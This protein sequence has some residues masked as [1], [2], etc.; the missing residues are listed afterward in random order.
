M[1]IRKGSDHFDNLDEIEFKAGSKIG[2]VH[3]MG[4]YGREGEGSGCTVASIRKL[5]TRRR[6]VS[7]CIFR[8]LC[9]RERTQRSLPPIEQE[10]RWAVEQVLG[11]SREKSPGLSSP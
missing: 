10:V 11:N 9:W 4:A 3:T 8:P 7:N 1:E 2:P 5:G 6:W